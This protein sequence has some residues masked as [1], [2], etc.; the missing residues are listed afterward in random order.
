M[1]LLLFNQ[2]GGPIYKRAPSGSG[3]ARI[4]QQSTRPQATETKRPNQQNTKR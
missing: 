2:Q 1:L 4:T 3:Y